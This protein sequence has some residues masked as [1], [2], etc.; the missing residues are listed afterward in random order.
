MY[1]CLTKGQGYAGFKKGLLKNT[2]TMYNLD[3]H[4]NQAQAAFESLT[5][6]NR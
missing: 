3:T 6:L 2:T 4:L 1:I 5:R